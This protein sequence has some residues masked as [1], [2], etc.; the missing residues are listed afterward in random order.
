M[1]IYLFGSTML[2]ALVTVLENNIGVKRWALPSNKDKQYSIEPAK[3][4]HFGKN[5]NI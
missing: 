2:L 3:D 1:P 5:S 4:I